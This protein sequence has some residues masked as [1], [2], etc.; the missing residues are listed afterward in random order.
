MNNLQ[1]IRKSKREFKN[2]SIAGAAILS[3]LLVSTP[4]FAGS[5]KDF[6]SQAVTSHPEVHALVS[7]QSAIHEEL[8][9]ARGLGLPGVNLEVR[10]GGY[11][12]KNTQQGFTEASLVLRQP[13][14]DGGKRRSEVARQ[15]ERKGSADN[16]VND[17]ANAI[18]LQAVQAYLEV[19]RAREILGISLKNLK[20]I[21]GIV[22]R[23]NASV[24]GG[25]GSSAD[26]EQAQA[27]LYEARNYEA[28]AQLQLMDAEALYRVLT[29][30][31]PGN[32]HLAKLPSSHAPP[33]GRCGG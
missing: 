29:G 25:G 33:H 18:A 31:M 5:L 1:I 27:R 11:I 6:V 14:Y 17:T 8:V 15:T 7:N 24:R 4:G 16:R 9:A 22:S 10:S 32:L 13:I 2:A 26:L 30:E 23:V 21:K 3:F 12:D 19:M 20:T 28:E